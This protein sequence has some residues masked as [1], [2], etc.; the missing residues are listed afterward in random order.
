MFSPATW[1][2]CMQ[3]SAETLTPGDVQRSE[4]HGRNSRCHLCALLEAPR[5]PQP[6]EAI[7][8]LQTFLT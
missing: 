5:G 4:Q 1:T 3:H 7:E 6:P 8:P 2:W